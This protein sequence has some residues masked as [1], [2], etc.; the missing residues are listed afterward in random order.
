[1]NYID[2]FTDELEVQNIFF[3][4]WRK[5]YK[6]IIGSKPQPK[7]IW[8]TRKDRNTTMS[9]NFGYGKTIFHVNFRYSS[10]GRFKP[11][12]TQNITDY[13]DFYSGGGSRS[14][15]GPSLFNKNRVPS[16]FVCDIR[17]DKGW[18]EMVDEVIKKYNDKPFII[19]ISNNYIIPKWEKMG[20][21]LYKSNCIDLSMEIRKKI[22]NKTWKYP[23]YY[24]T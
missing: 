24:K 14:M 19:S 16:R 12:G 10:D 20:F 13:G 11:V 9:R 22:N 5:E 17:I 8:P 15:A 3:M 7:D 1:M 2:R 6:N 18:S 21:K 23:L 4:S